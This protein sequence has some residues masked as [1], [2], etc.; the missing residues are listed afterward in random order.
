MAFSKFGLKCP[1]CEKILLIP[2]RVVHKRL[3]ENRICPKCCSSRQFGSYLMATKSEVETER[4]NR[5]K[6]VVVF[7]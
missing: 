3:H 1:I 7:S 6:E 2:Y 4:E 5:H